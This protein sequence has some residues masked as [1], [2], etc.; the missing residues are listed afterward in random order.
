MENSGLRSVDIWLVLVL[1][2]DSHTW[3]MLNICLLLN[4]TP[5]L[6]NTSLA[7]P[8]TNQCFMLFSVCV[9]RAENTL[10]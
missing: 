2:L 3:V 6:D 9:K 5:Q 8:V 7:Q 10:Q 4:W 1:L